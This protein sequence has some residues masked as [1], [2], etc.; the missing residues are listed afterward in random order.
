MQLE[1]LSRQTGP[2]GQER[3]SGLRIT[4]HSGRTLSAWFKVWFETL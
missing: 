1:R 3:W 2:M 4:R